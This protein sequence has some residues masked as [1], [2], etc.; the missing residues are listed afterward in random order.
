MI[1]VLIADESPVVHDNISRRLALEDDVTV[2]G[3]A[4]DGESAVQ[5][6]LWLRPDIAVVDAGL[7]GMDGGQTTQMLA[8]CL[9]GTGVI[10]MSMEAENEAYRLAMLAGAREFLQKPFRGDDLVAAVRRV[11][12]FGQRRAAAVAEASADPP[13]TADAADLA[14]ERPA[15]PSRP[16]TVLGEVTAVVAGKGGVGKT[17]VAINLAAALRAG[18]S[19]RV[20]LVDFSLQFGDV[21]AVLAL[22]TDHTIGDLLE[23]DHISDHELVRDTLVAGPAGTSVLLAPNTP[24]VADYISVTQLTSLVDTLRADFDHIIIDTPSY[25]SDA[26]LSALGIAEHVVMVTD[27]SVPGVKNARLVRRVLETLNV[28]PTRVLVVANHRESTGELDGSGAESFLGAAISG[29]IPFDPKVVAT[30]VNK[31]VPFV[32]A[33]PASRPSEAILGIARLIDPASAVAA[34]GDKSGRKKRSRRI[35]SFSR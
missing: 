25:L 28:L 6:A 27:L 2:C 12:A 16:A 26:T 7:P 32:V 35:L 18:E 29:D 20:V 14:A 13:A 11:H 1:R 9:P 31:G 22:P 4:S 21:A 15:A 34:S 17:V 23:E 33:E 30:S 3:T 19:R 8:Q 10:M 5:E 24:E